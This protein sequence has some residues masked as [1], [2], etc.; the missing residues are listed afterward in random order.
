[1]VGV[2]LELGQQHVGDDDALLHGVVIGHGE[3]SLVG[4]SDDV[5]HVLV[6]QGA[7][8]AEEILELWQPARKLLIGCQV[9][10]KLFVLDRVLVQ[11]IQ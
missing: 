3:A 2:L 8:Q 1:M 7:Q 10:R 5:L 9:L 11:V 6:L 4:V